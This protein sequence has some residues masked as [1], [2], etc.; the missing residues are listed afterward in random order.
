MAAVV[1]AEK[2]K[3]QARISHDLISRLLK[4]TKAKQKASEQAKDQAK[5]D[6]IANLAELKKALGKALSTGKKAATKPKPEK[7]QAPEPSPV[8]QSTPDC[9]YTGCR[10]IYCRPFAGRDDCV[11][12]AVSSGEPHFI[13]IST[14]QLYKLQEITSEAYSAKAERILGD[15]IF[16]YEASDADIRAILETTDCFYAGTD[17]FDVT[18]PD[19][20]TPISK[21]L[22]NSP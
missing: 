3:S 6:A 8:P 9:T 14:R 2:E 4:D 22:E 15:I 1:A 10:V 21:P 20:N 19:N 7:P 16:L 12:V 17:T 18:V 13:N 5:Y 11:A